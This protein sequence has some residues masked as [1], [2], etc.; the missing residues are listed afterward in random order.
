MCKKREVLIQLIVESM[1]TSFVDGLIGIALGITN[2]ASEFGGW[3][4]VI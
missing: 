2:T 4:V 1:V 3:S